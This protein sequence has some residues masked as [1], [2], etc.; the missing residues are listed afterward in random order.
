MQ[1]LVERTIVFLVD[2]FVFVGAFT[3]LQYLKII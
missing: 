2:V 1:V 3:M